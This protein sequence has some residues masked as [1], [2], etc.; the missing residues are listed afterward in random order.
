MV[1]SIKNEILTT[2]EE[3]GLVE[4][5][6]PELVR[7]GTVLD[8]ENAAKLMAMD[9][10]RNFG[11]SDIPFM[12]IGNRIIL[13]DDMIQRIDRI[14]GAPDSKAL[15]QQALDLAEEGLLGSMKNV[16]AKLGVS[17]RVVERLTDRDGKPIRGVAAADILNRTIQVVQGNE[18]ELTEEVVHFMVIAMA[19]LNDPLYRSMRKRIKEEPEYQEVLAEYSDLDTYNEDDLID[20][21]ITKVIVNRLAP[22]EKVED[23]NSR[24]WNR[25]LSR[26]KQLFNMTSDPFKEAAMQ[27]F[28]QDLSRYSNALN[29]S[30]RDTI[31]RSLGNIQDQIREN[32]LERHNNLVLDEE[33]TREMLEGRLD[34][35]TIDIIE[36]DEGTFVR[37]RYKGELVTRRVTDRSSVEMFKSFKNL[38]EYKR[39]GKRK[40]SKAA[41]VAGTESHDIAHQVLV[42]LARSKDYKQHFN[43][44]N[45]HPS[46]QFKGLTALKRDSGIGKGFELMEKE[47]RRILDEMVEKKKGKKDKIDLYAELRIYNEKDDTGGTIDVLF[48]TKEGKGILRDYKFMSPKNGVDYSSG[49]MQLTLDP[50]RGKKGE[51]FANQQAYYKQT[52]ENEYGF[53]T[54][55]IES[56]RVI[57]GHL[58]LEYKDGEFTGK[59]LELHMGPASDR[60]LE[61]FPLADFE[62]TGDKEIDAQLD[63]LYKE[64]AK[65][66]EATRLSPAQRKAKEI[67]VEAI[68]ALVVRDADITSM[69]TEI[70]SALKFAEE[71]MKITDPKEK[72]YLT[73][74]QL[75][76]LIDTLSLFSDLRAAVNA[77][78]MDLVS[79]KKITKEQ[80]DKKME[81]VNESYQPIK[82]TI[83]ALQ[84]LSVTRIMDKLKNKPYLI[85]IGDEVYSTP[86]GGLISADTFLASEYIENEYFKAFQDLLLDAR[87]R[88]EFNQKN[89]AKKWIAL[90]SKLEEWAASKGI[91]VLDAYD[92]LID[93]K[94][95][96]KRRKLVTV[97]SKEFKEKRDEL[98]SEALDVD[99][100]GVVGEAAKFM[101]TYY[102]I[103]EGAKEK[104][105][106][107]R[108][109]AE[110]YAEIIYFGKNTK[111]Y[112]TYMNAWDSRR[113]VWGSKNN[114]AWASEESLRYLEV[115]PE[116]RDE[117]FSEKYKEILKEDTLLEYYNAWTEQMEDF[118]KIVQDRQIYHTTVPNILPNTIQ[119]FMRKDA[120]WSNFANNLLIDHSIEVENEEQVGSSK[121]KVVPLPFLMPPRD[122]NGEIMTDMI[123]TRLTNVMILFG[124]AVYEHAA[125]SEV[126]GE[127]RLIKNFLQTRAKEVIIS[128]DGTFLRK[129]GVNELEVDEVSANT[130][131]RYDRLMDQ[132]LY[133]IMLSGKGASSGFESGGRKI[134]WSKIARSAKFAFTVKA[135]TLPIRAATAALAS[136]RVFTSAR[137][138]AEENYTKEAFAKAW[139]LAKKD[140]QKYK[141]IIR[142]ADVF[143]IGE[144]VMQERRSRGDWFSKH[145]NASYFFS[146]LSL[147]DEVGDAREIVGLMY[148]LGLDEKGNIRR[149]KDLPEGATNLVDMLEFTK[150]G[151]V[152]EDSLDPMVMFQVRQ[153]F[154]AERYSLTGTKGRYS[155]SISQADYLLQLVE[156]LR[157]FIPGILRAKWGNTRY[158]RFKQSLDTG[159]YKAMFKKAGFSSKTKEDIEEDATMLE[160]LKSNLSSLQGLISTMIRLKNFTVSAEERKRRIEDGTWDMEK[161][162]T[163]Y[164]RRVAWVKREFD[165]AKMSTND[166]NIHNMDLEGF[167]QHLQGTVRAGV[168]ETR[169]NLMLFVA[170]LLAAG[171]KPDREQDGTVRYSYNMFLYMLQRILL[172]TSAF[173]NPYEL[174]KLNRSFI[175]VLGL[176]E[177]AAKITGNTADV[178]FDLVRYGKDV[179]PGDRSGWLHYSSGMVPG[180]NTLKWMLEPK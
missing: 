140:T 46:K 113:N 128:D 100:P 53:G 160:M 30:T 158:N 42:H 4:Q 41:R 177:D 96:G 71:K 35:K 85:A 103:K 55:G 6:G 86:V 43:V 95:E 104:F 64:H 179:S 36:G 70:T 44:V 27:M 136:R 89:H 137:L 146:L 69:L 145:A 79:K 48:V 22:Q 152:K 57:P 111:G 122:A 110:S 8:V 129:K 76:D 176:L 54:A 39:V 138:K 105:L 94:V 5:K 32:L 60:F 97:L 91:S 107:D 51:G 72:G 149:L 133:K 77:K 135:L 66:R 151:N 106:E 29:V 21:A 114:S 180:A 52:L 166:P 92:M 99:S 153:M 40:R 84:D 2:L 49:T 45:L 10:A 38:K 119:A 81:K 63:A 161:D 47:L 118:N 132:L 82:D 178:L 144:L 88:A 115:K 150:D 59:I 130:I 7:I 24:W 156:N 142:Y 19:E 78:Y 93:D 175:P 83:S 25:F 148:N 31:F 116:K 62:K 56:A 120:V 68:K 90:D 98:I 147:A 37:Y 126:E 154:Y 162:E 109:R 121:S 123:S 17:E 173:I 157:S 11:E 168:H 28:Q 164:N 163:N 171:M 102:Q 34:P 159:L 125:A 26:I 169:V 74:N 108:K 67:I 3:K 50:F 80:K 172:E 61:Q 14:I 16:M 131:E 143:N 124:N 65:L 167:A 20:E 117:A 12:S 170:A 174:Y 112:T 18:N 58:K 33:V 127:A 23:R 9:F 141:A 73:D 155:T 165:L 13:N 101:K 134:L 15:D 139:E 87:G 1:C 75:A